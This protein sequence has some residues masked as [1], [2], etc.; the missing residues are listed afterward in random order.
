MSTYGSD[1]SFKTLIHNFGCYITLGSIIVLA[2]EEIGCL[3]VPYKHVTSDTDLLVGMLIVPVYKE[4]KISVG[5]GEV[6]YR[7]KNL[8]AV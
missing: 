8:F 1:I 5:S 2:E 6:K 4:I 7:E 3:R